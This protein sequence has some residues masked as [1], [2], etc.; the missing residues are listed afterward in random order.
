MSVTRS[1]IRKQKQEMNQVPYYDAILAILSIIPP[2]VL[3]ILDLPSD[4]IADID[5]T[6]MDDDNTGRACA[7]YGFFISNMDLT[8]QDRLVCGQILGCAASN[9]MNETV[10]TKRNLDSIDALKNTAVL[11]TVRE[12]FESTSGVPGLFGDAEREEIARLDAYISMYDKD[13]KDWGLRLIQNGTI[14]DDETSTVPTLMDALFTNLPGFV[15][16]KL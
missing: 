9:V 12:W 13:L 8:A 4:V 10:L 16:S 6:R 15:M 7:M 2:H 5:D 14:N 3:D 1:E 11:D